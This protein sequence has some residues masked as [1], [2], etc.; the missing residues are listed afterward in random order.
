HPAPTNPG[1]LIESIRARTPARLLVGRAGPAYR[2][3]TQLELRRDHAAAVDAVRAELEAARDFGPDFVARWR[4]SGVQ[5]SAT[6]K[7][8]CL[9][10]PD[11]GRPLSDAARPQVQQECPASADLQV[12]IGDGLSCAAVVA[13]VPGLLPLLEEG[14]RARGWRFG[15]PFV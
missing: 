13:Q 12:V 9:L 4:L 2:T 10:R 8:A 3:T 14:A 1:G 5:T 15:R 11:R 7:A 6:H